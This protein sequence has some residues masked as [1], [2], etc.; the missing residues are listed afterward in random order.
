[1]RRFRPWILLVGLALMVVGC[2]VAPAIK[3]EKLADGAK[4]TGQK[5]ALLISGQTEKRHIKSVELTYK[6]LLNRGFSPKN[7]II[8][9][10]K[11]SQGRP[12]P[13]HAP[14]DA[15]SI[16]LGFDY[17]ANEIRPDDLLFVYVTNHGRFDKE[18]KAA[19]IGLI[20][21]YLDEFDIAAYANKIH[22]RI[23]IFMFTECYGGCFANRLR[24]E[25]R[26]TL[27]PTTDGKCSSYAFSQTFFE[28]FGACAADLDGNSRVSI[29]EA[30]YYAQSAK[31]YG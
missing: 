22:P 4:I 25:N 28:A 20:G 3:P 16:G 15:K 6:T 8:F 11:G 5:Y 1:M 26:I 17:L 10:G 24:G 9:D 31:K 29:R 13:V 23:G 7:V 18:K 2:V 21:K 27:A 19:E 30:F 12:Y 14:A